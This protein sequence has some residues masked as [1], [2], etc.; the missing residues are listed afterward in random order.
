MSKRVILILA[1]VIMP[2]H[3]VHAVIY[4]DAWPDK[5]VYYLKEPITVY[6]FASGL[7]LHLAFPTNCQVDYIMDGI[8][9]SGA[10][11]HCLT[12]VTYA[13]LPCHWTIEHSMGAYTPGV[14]T[15]WVM[16][17]MYPPWGGFCSPST[18]Y[19]EVITYD[20]DINESGRVDFADYSR[21]ANAWKST[22]SDYNW[23]PSCNLAEPNDII[24]EYD[25]KALIDN[26]LMGY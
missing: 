9:D 14:G 10:P 26:W 20:G 6:I 21:L 4:L 13:T 5:D 19:F 24:D 23:D 16:P 12:I 17:Y 11:P 15:H 18:G 1:M 7:P 22:P 2:I 8:Y 25:L 3:P